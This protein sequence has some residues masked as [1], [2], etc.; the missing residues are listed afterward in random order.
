MTSSLQRWGAGGL[1]DLAVAVD[2][3]VDLLDDVQVDVVLRVLDAR[4]AKSKR[5]DSEIERSV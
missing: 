2:D 3:G 1:G 5:I 4:P